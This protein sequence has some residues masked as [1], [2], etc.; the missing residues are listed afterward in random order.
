MC[1]V[2]IVFANT[3]RFMSKEEKN[4]KLKFHNEMLVSINYGRSLC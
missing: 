3:S 1:V 2:G 4:L